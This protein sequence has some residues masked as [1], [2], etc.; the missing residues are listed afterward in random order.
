MDIA[1]VAQDVIQFATLVLCAATL[2]IGFFWTRRNK[3]RRQWATPIATWVFHRLLFYTYVQS[4]GVLSL[5]NGFFG[6]WSTVVA[7][8]GIV[9]IF[10]TVFTLNLLNGKVIK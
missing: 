6:M 8:H 4:S 2:V 5:P 10:M 1:H 7:F 3:L 9:V